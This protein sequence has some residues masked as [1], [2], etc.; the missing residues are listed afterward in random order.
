M[1]HAGFR[2]ALPGSGWRTTDRT[3]TD[4]VE[5]IY[6]ERG[7]GRRSLQ[8]QISALTPTRPIASQAEVN[9]WA[10]AAMSA[11]TGRAVDGH[12]AVCARAERRWFQSTSVNGAA[13]APT[14]EFDDFGLFC[15]I[16]DSP[17]VFHVRLFE[18]AAPGRLSGD[19][20]PLAE[21]L[22]AS[23]RRSAD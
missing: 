14:A 2:Y 6:Y 23:V 1:S 10:R 4:T 15:A 5:T 7:F 21:T 13:A 11:A 8:I 20:A 9:A 3:R 16:P 22:F 19:A 18:R 12:G 17:R